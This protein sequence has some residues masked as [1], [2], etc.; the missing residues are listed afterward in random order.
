MSVNWYDFRIRLL[1]G[2]EVHQRF[3]EVLRGQA[4][5]KSPSID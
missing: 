1:D 5:D 2:V 3:G 4:W